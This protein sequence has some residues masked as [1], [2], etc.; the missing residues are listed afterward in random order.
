VSDIRP[1][2]YVC[3]SFV[4]YVT[5]SSCRRLLDY[6]KNYF[7]VASFQDGETK[8]ALQ[9]LINKRAGK[10]SGRLQGS[11]GDGSHGARRRRKNKKDSD[12]AV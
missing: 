4:I 9:R 10:A 12:V 2:W 1:E 11:K 6:A 3:L 7:D 5:D 8:Q